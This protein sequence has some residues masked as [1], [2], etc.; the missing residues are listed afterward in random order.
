M[1]KSSLG[2]RMKSYE[3][4]FSQKYPQRFPLILRFDGIHFHSQVIKWK[5]KKPFD[6]RMVDAMVA[7]TKALCEAIPGSQIAYSQSDEI[8]LLIRD[9]ATN[10]TQPW[11]DKKVN[12]VLTD[13][14]TI[15]SNAFNFNF[16]SEGMPNS[17]DHLAKFD[18]RGYIV[19]EYEINNAFLWRQQDASRNSVQMVAHANFS[20]KQCE[21]KN[22]GALQDMLM[23]ERDINWN[24]L[25]VHERRGF[26]VLKKEVEIRV[27]ARD[28]NHQLI[29]PTEYVP[30][31]RNVWA[32]D[33]DIPIFSKDVEYI[34]QFTRKAP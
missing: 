29:E 21:F 6:K 7:T 5:S 10:N 28:E 15:A 26:C 24:S 23:L 16:F 1:D 20:H 34:N 25:P 18:C 31:T 4:A 19:P 32:V 27:P 30:A 17:L 2:D 22:V 13:A 33:L 11:H 9:D 3:N 14:A 12:K 8:T